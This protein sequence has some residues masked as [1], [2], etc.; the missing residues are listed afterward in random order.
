MEERERASERVV[1][2]KVVCSHLSH[3]CRRMAPT[4][5]V[6]FLLSLRHF[7]NLWP[8]SLSRRKTE[9]LCLSALRLAPRCFF[10][11]CD[12]RLIGCGAGMDTHEECGY[13]YGTEFGVPDL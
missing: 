12:Y 1:R 6:F 7:R 2:G 10:L 5:A 8:L 9:L 13:T 3:S 4:R 11:L